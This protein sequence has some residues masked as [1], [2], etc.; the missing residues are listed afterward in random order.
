MNGQPNRGDKIFSHKSDGDAYKKSRAKRKWENS[1]QYLKPAQKDR[2]VYEHLQCHFKI[3]T[4]YFKNYFESI[5]TE[6]Y[7]I[8]TGR[9]SLSIQQNENFV[10][11]YS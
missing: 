11:L 10:E 9:L 4:S 1:Y 7:F 3:I 6:A 2:L 8:K 5:H